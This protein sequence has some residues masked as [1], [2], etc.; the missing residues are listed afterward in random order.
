[1]KDKVTI[2]LADFCYVTD[3]GLS[4]DSLPLGIG[5]IA[6]YCLKKLGDH[7]DVRLFIIAEDL[8]RAVEEQKPNIIGLSNF[9]W[10]EN[11][12]AA[13]AHKLKRD[14]PDIVLVTGGANISPHSLNT[15]KIQKKRVPLVTELFAHKQDLIVLEKFKCVDYFVHGEGEIPV[16]NLVESYIQADGDIN[17]LKKGEVPGCST[18]V[19][20]QLR[21]G[22]PGENISDLDI[23]RSPY[24]LGLYD[25]IWSKYTLMPQ[26]ETNRGC[27]FRCEF[28]TIGSWSSKI[29]KHSLEYVKEEIHYL[30][31]HSPSR[32]LRF[33]DSNFGLLPKD[34]E[35]AEF[36]AE[37]RKKTSYP[38]GIRVYTA[39]SS[40]N[41]RVKQVMKYFADILPLNL[42]VQSMSDVV[43][44]NVNRKNQS[45][46][47]FENMRQFAVE[48]NMMMSTE[49]ICGLPGETLESY[50]QGFEELLANGFESITAGPLTLIKGSGLVT[51]DC[52]EKYKFKTKYGLIR[53]NV[54]KFDNQIVCEYHELPVESDSF[55]EEDYFI[56]L[57]FSYFMY[58]T[59][60]GGWFKEFLLFANENKIQILDVFK[61]LLSD[62]KQ[63]PLYNK[64]LYKIIE[65]V[66][67]CYF[68]DIN[69]LKTAIKDAFE[70]G[71]LDNVYN[72][73]EELLTWTG[74][75][76]SLEYKS[77]NV[78]EIKNA[79]KCVY[80][81]KQLFRNEEDSKEFDAILDEL[82]VYTYEKIIS[83]YAELKKKEIVTIT[84]NIPDWLKNYKS[85][86]K[87]ATYKGK[88]KFNIE[89]SVRNIQQH[90]E[91][92]D[93]NHIST[94]EARFFYYF[95]AL[96][97]SNMQ[98]YVTNVESV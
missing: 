57:S 78:C 81:D 61:K 1:M 7:V 4:K 42:S 65:K 28:C 60:R 58:L 86:C 74:R 13:V 85:G 50:C 55:S 39:E 38:T 90:Q 37:L 51:D 68:D 88:K 48:N 47:E 43:L 5:T 18:V 82:E 91:L 75:L 36:I 95:D 14:Y 19:D 84:Y 92:H 33:A 2:Y 6:S 22:I 63:F 20:G 9:E 23:Y 69:Q 96:V 3:S 72:Y 87:L 49:L 45:I 52:R 73:R 64:I 83:P 40:C 32:I 94:M 8:F 93:V 97:G 46:E 10:S 67:L 16:V 79:I 12:T 53:N 41:E 54:T 30:Y 59:F 44:K 70:K 25:E 89:L 29:R 98:R 56:M 62:S 31:E 15:D 11:L 34:V 17:Q 77:K 35:V 71:E 76:L 66:K 24:I 27:P 26:V 21:W 80:E